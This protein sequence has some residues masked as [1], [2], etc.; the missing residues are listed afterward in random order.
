[1]PVGRL[2]WGTER[3]LEFIELRLFWDGVVN[4][5]EL[6]GTF[7][8][9]LQRGSADFARYLDIAPANAAYSRAA[10]GYVRSGAFRPRFTTPDPVRHLSHLR[11]TSEGALDRGF[12]GSGQM[13]SFDIV[14]GPVRRIDPLVLRSIPDA[15]RGR[16][17][18]E[19]TYQSTLRTKPGRRCIAPHALAFDGFRWHARA[20]C[21]G[22]KTFKHFT[23]A[24]V[25]SPGDPRPTAIDSATD[26]LWHHRV[27][28][29]I[30]PYP[31]LSAGQ[32]KTVEADYGMTGGVSVTDVR[33]FF[34]WHF[35]KGLG[36]EEDAAG[37]PPQ[38]QH[39]VV[40]LNRNDVM[41]ALFAL[42]E[43]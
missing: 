13:P 9:S 7:G 34:L 41:A 3:R 25:S 12:S 19:I 10:N 16:Q 21:A 23:R 14:P 27:R 28:T 39:I 5:R 26:K 40:L 29:I 31:G 43:A 2:R 36:I 42:D 37:K 17:E 15:I 30:G 33:A 4:R 6:A 1:M 35:L 38:D 32:R 20:Y 18:I 22:D 11:L 24:R 8:I